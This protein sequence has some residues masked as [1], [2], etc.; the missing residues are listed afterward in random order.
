[1]SVNNNY[2][3]IEMAYRNGLI[4]MNLQM[5]LTPILGGVIALSTNWLAI[6]M[7]FR[8]HTPKYIFG[9]RVPFTPGLIPKERARLAARISQA[10]STK[11]LTPEVLVQEL[12]NPSV[13]PI[14]DITL[15]EILGKTPTGQMA[16]FVPALLEAVP[17]MLEDH[18]ALDA[19]LAELTYKVIDENLGTLA[20]MFI[21]KEKIYQSIKGNVVAYLADPS[22]HQALQGHLEAGVP[23]PEKIANYSIKENL[24]QFVQT[25][26]A[27]NMLRALVEYIATHM[28]IQAMVE[29]KLNTFEIA[30]AEEIILSVAGRELKLIVWLGGILGVLIGLLSLLF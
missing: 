5:I 20:K 22:T 29:N 4:R 17:K 3:L 23:L 28:P 30:E 9:W 14:P 15:G 26:T 10:I 19:K 24:T 13:W 7:L 18:P 21:S 16:N 1:M 12:S 8:P 6:K 2:L 27:Q 25:E 11:L